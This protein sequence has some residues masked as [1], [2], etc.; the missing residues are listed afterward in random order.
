MSG[1]QML[2]DSF[3]DSLESATTF[4]LGSFSSNLGEFLGVDADGYANSD[5]WLAKEEH[6][7]SG[8]ATE[9]MASAILL[10]PLGTTAKA[11]L[12]SADMQL[13]EFPDDILGLDTIQK[14]APLAGGSMAT[15]F[16]GK[17]GAMPVALKEAT[18]F[19]DTLLNEAVTMMKLKHPNVVQVYGIWKDSE[20]RVFMVLSDLSCC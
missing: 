2:A 14:G 9:N 4:T 3:P 20:Q 15:V 6:W 18:R 13:E 7:R 17:Y 11:T 5:M 8:L 19:S 12:R 10:D 16:N 1:E